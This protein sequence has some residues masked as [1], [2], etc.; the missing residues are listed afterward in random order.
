MYACGYEIGR[1]FFEVVCRL[2]DRSLTFRDPPH[3]GGQ[4]TML[5]NALSS[6]LSRFAEETA[7]VRVLDSPAAPGTS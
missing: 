1:G 3:P 2:G 7:S 4:A 5:D 6:L